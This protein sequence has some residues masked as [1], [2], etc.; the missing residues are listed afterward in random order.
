MQHATKTWS[1]VTL[2][3]AAGVLMLDPFPG[4]VPGYAD[5]YAR[6]MYANTEFNLQCENQ[7]VS[8]GSCVLQ[9]PLQVPP[10]GLAVL[11]VLFL[12]SSI[13]NHRGKHNNCATALQEAASRCDRMPECQV[14]L[15]LSKPLGRAINKRTGI[16]WN[17]FSLLRSPPSL[18]RL[19]RVLV[20]LQLGWAMFLAHWPPSKAIEMEN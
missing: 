12:L 6:S 17:K 18:Q 2:Q 3:P 10:P 1:N 8:K 15:G 14:P 19:C 16:A 9:L 5:F 4:T 7:T 13:P 11:R 20:T